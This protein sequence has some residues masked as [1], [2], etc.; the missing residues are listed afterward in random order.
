PVPDG[1]T[2]T[3]L[4]LTM[5]A[6]AGA[7]TLDDERS[8]EVV[9][10]AAAKAALMGAKGNSGVILSQILAGFAAMPD[11]DAALDGASLARAFARARDAAYK[12]VSQPKEGTI[13]TAIAAAAD[14]A[15]LAGNASTVIV[16]DAVVTATREAVD[17][18]PDLLP[19]LKEA[20]VVDAG[21]QGL[22]VLLDGMLRG[23]RGEEGATAAADLGAIDPAWLA[24]T[25]RT[26]AHGDAQSGFC[27]E[28]VVT[29]AA[30]DADALRTRMHAL[31]NSVLVVGGDDV[32]RVHVHTHVPDDALAHARTLG[33]VSHEKVDDMEAQFRALAASSPSVAPTEGIAVVAVALGDGIAELFESMG[34]RVV[35][36]GQTM[37]PSAGDIR[38]A[39]EA[40]GASEVIVLPDN[41]NVV[42]AAKLAAEGLAT[43]VAVVETRSIPQGVAALVA[44]NTEAPFDENVAAMNDAIASVTTAEITLAARPTRI[45]DIDVRAG[46][47][48]GLIDGDLAVAAE[49][50]AEAAHQCVARI[51]AARDASL[52]TLYVGEGETED[53]ANA[54]ADGLRERHGLDVDVV[55][56][57]QPHY[58][59]FVGVE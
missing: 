8:A 17:R 16:L 41:K 34:A 52:I 3:N 26:H 54:I 14:A 21:A 15:A 25:V 46:Q 47:P 59:Y 36:G 42:M 1:D 12:V 40:T 13:L 43:L 56:G 7:I 50:I 35:R 6:A 55:H 38:A 57:G 2:G 20:G 9:A 37:N 11:H 24:A 4:S 53:A 48:I 5:Q 49:T 58:P 10:T 44:L 30:I 27:T 39:I 28:F 31:G 19:V 33:D 51:L 23:L 29:G 22:Y 32:V 18:T 45:H